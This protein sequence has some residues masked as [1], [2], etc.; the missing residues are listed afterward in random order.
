MIASR[1]YRCAM[2]VLAVTLMLAGSGCSRM[3]W[4]SQADFDT[5]N[6]LQRKQF[7]PRWTIP[8]TTVEPDPR[9]RF[10]DPF[11][12]D[13][14]PLP[15]DDLAASQYMQAVHG[16]PGY[17]SWHKFGESMSVENPA[18]LANFG[19]APNEPYVDY[20]LSDGLTTVSASSPEVS[21][22]PPELVP[23]IENMTLAQAI[24]LA[25]I[26]SRDYQ[27]QIENAYLSALLL[28]LDQFQFNVRYLGLGNREPTGELSY[29]NVPTTSDNVGFNSRFGMSQFLPTGGQWI[30][31]AANNTLWLFSGGNQT[32]SASVLS[33]SLTQP[34]LLGAGRKFMLENLTQSERE[35]LYDLRTLARYRKLFFAD[36]VAAGQGGGA[37][38]GGA[39]NVSGTT[40]GGTAASASGVG[41]LGLLQQTQVIR[42]QRDNIQGLYVQ[43]ERQRELVSQTTFR[44][45][46]VGALPLGITFPNGLDAKIEYQPNIRTLVWIGTE[47]MS[48]AELTALLAISNDAEYQRA[49]GELF[50]QLRTGVITT[51]ILQLVT[52]LS[53]QEI[54]L[55]NAE[56]NYEDAL[57]RYKLFLGL[58]TDMRVTLDQSLLQQFQ[59]I[60]PSIKQLELEVLEL[61]NQ[62]AAIDYKD[63]PL[64][65]LRS[66]AKRLSGVIDDV[67][68]NGIQSIVDDFERVAANTPQRLSKLKFEKSRDAVEN[69]LERDRVIFRTIR[70]ALERANDEADLNP[71]VVTLYKQ[72]LRALGSDDLTLK[73][74]KDALAAMQSAREELFTIVQ[75]LR[76][77]QVGLRIELITLPDF[78]MSQETAVA[79]AL[80]NRLDLMNSKARVMD[81]RR[82]MEVAANRL[83]AVLNLVAT[84]DVRTP[85]G[86]NTPLNFRGADSTFRFGVQM[87]APIDQVAE[88][89]AYRAALVAYQRL[90]R[91]YM[92]QE[93][94]VK[95]EVRS[96]WRQLNVAHLNFETGR[97]NLRQAALQLEIVVMNAN[98]PTKGVGLAATTVSSG[99][100]GLNLL[101]ALNSV[102]QAQNNLVQTW[103]DYE[104]SRI[105]IHRDMDIMVIDERGL[106]VD[107][108]Y[109]NLPGASSSLPSE[110]ANVQP[111]DPEPSALVN[112][113]ERDGSVGVVRLIAGSRSVQAPKS[114]GRTSVPAGRA[115]W[116]SGWRGRLLAN[117]P[118][119][120]DA[121]DVGDRWTGARDGQEIP[122]PDYGDGEG[123]ARQHAKRLAD[124]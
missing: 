115:G 42:N 79:I 120:M 122:V 69:A 123:D 24:E 95:F 15:P 117:D 11:D 112:P 75:N 6:L 106:W 43:T 2:T 109:Q 88:R 63:P 37:G 7:D 12:A 73:Q 18:W 29:V 78:D 99:N 16:M 91:D 107:P 26:H 81:A 14:P 25:N 93:D 70:E 48:S 51:D 113:L 82:V 22:E 64:T 33:Y 39:T 40:V 53:G 124:E 85:T 60:D 80:E 104:R 87:T 66:A 97:K 90:R 86:D 71:S 114:V 62:T 84:G 9:S 67:R 4:R 36:A 10:F 38:G 13:C 68:S 59:L 77:V 92:R 52:Q 76:V 83:E 65:E 54:Q 61:A 41:Y 110:P 46:K 28:T 74:R 17:K 44:R 5:Y 118:G 121:D 100:T 35:V 47:P 20:D 45:L 57:D 30:V 103:V 56:R 3:F 23:S 105:N 34:L 98:G 1:R 89:N 55:R 49:V 27:T 58:P 21:K 31:E 119:S 32:T 111:P 19:M 102:L 108:V 94:Q 96:D 72:T 116:L 101:Q 50:D 8:R